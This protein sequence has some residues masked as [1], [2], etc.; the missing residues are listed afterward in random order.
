MWQS[1]FVSGQQ[2]SYAELNKEDSPK[3]GEHTQLDIKIYHIRIIITMYSIDIG[4]ETKK[5]T[6]PMHMCKLEI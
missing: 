6:R 1:I 3:S 4:S 5:R 2:I